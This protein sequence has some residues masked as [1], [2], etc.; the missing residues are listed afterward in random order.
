[1]NKL[2]SLSVF[3]MLVFLLTACTLGVDTDGDVVTVYSE[4]HYDTDQALFD[5]FEEETGIEVQ[6]IKAGADE[7]ITR[8]ET[9]GE[10]TEA[11]LLIVSDAG[12]LHLAKDKGLLQAVE[13][14]GIDDNVPSQY[15]DIDNMWIGLTMRARVLVYHPDRVNEEELSTYEAL[16]ELSQ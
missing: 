9:E 11:D 5:Q 13:S 7:L 1:M 16:T 14:D 12:R 3:T 10:D 6:V 8:L 4:R 15:R 2:L